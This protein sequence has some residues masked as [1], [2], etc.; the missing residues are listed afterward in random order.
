M[1]QR[2]RE[3]ERGKYQDFVIKNGRF[4]G[5]FEEMYQKFSDPWKLL[6]K[7]KSGVIH[8]FHTNYIRKI[9][10]YMELIFPKL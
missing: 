10:Q 7:N 9:L 2:D 3:T 8:K 6:K 5:K 4:I 1:R